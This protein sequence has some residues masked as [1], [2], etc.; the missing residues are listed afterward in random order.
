MA[1]QSLY[2]AAY[3]QDDWRV[4]SKLTLNLGLRYDVELPRTERYNRMNYFDP[5][6]RSPLARPQY[7]DLRGG[8][9]FVGVDGNSRSQYITDRNNFAP[10]FGFAY[11]ATSKTVVRGGFGYFFGASEQTATGTVGPFGF[12]TENPWQT[13]LDNGL[14]PYRLLRDPFP[15]GFQPPPGAS[16]G[17]LTS[18]GGRLEAPV[19][20]TP[21]P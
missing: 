7:S 14:T 15:Q 2:H 3:L 19:R 11:Q 12:R 16:Q 20:D 5:A 21:N 9:V 17:L 18:V 10:R 6:A 8:V 1:A 13:S 4:T